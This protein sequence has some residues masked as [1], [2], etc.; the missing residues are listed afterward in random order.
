MIPLC[1]RL[2]ENEVFIQ[3]IA[4]KTYRGMYNE[5][6][7]VPSRAGELEMTKRVY[8]ADDRVQIYE[9]VMFMSMP[10]SY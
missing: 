1:S 10:C 5:Q 7:Q 3:A 2:R 6:A 4:C 8:I 9:H